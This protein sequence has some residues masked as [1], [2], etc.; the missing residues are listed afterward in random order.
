MST[1]TLRQGKR[2]SWL[3]ALLTFSLLGVTG[4]QAYWLKNAYELKEEKFEREVGQALA[5]VSERLD[6]LESLRFLSESIQIE[7][8][9]TDKLS[10]SAARPFGDSVNPAAGNLKLTMRLGGDTV[11]EFKSDRGESPVLI[12]Y[13]YGDTNAREMLVKANPDQMLQKGLQLDMLLRKLVIHEIRRKNIEQLLD[14]RT[15]DSV[16]SFELKSRG[17][18]L[19]FEFS[20]INEKQVK[21]QS[22]NWR[23]NQDQHTAALFPNDFF[24]NQILSIS[25]PKKSNYIMRSMWL[26]LLISLAL[27]AGVIV[28]FYRTL[29]F[30]LRQKRISEVKTDFINNMTHEFKTPIAT[31][32]LAIDALNN[33]KVLSNPE[34]IAHYSKM[35]KQENQRMNLQVES[36]LRMALMDKQELVLN[37]KEV[38]IQNIVKDCIEHVSLQLE[39]RNGQL[40][41]FFNDNNIRLKADENH[42]A[43]C[44]INIIDNAIKYSVGPPQI[45]VVTEATQNYFIL[46]ISDKGVGMT[47]DEQK[48]IFDRFYRVSSGDLHNIKGHGLGLSYA[49]GIIDAHG[50]RI[51]VESEKG[52]GSK[53]Y[54]YLP[55]NN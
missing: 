2:L 7:P 48:H 39:N 54:I 36:V 47:K 5:E 50:G 34:K 6:N 51:E 40:N 9:F 13:R 24:S 46:V 18:D 43:N 35:I 33:N 53:F 38:N 26:M 25:F 29:S 28:A 4:I 10:P 20:V 3:I 49:K 42:L 17:I 19:P 30:S 12:A 23:E 15:L 1:Q 16:I 55:I 44:I 45:K 22:H 11:M 32:N 52:K 8:F 27:T 14:K 21:L 37:L 41:K 31:I